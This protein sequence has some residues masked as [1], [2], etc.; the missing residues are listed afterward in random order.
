MVGNGI[1]LPL[2]GWTART[3]DGGWFVTIIL[4]IA[5]PAGTAQKEVTAA[6]EP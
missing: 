6:P 3:G 2:A 5:G 1:V 4:L